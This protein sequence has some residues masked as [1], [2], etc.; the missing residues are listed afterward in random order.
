M[1]L[2]PLA[3]SLLH[4][5]DVLQRLLLSMLHAQGKGAEYSS[6]SA[7]RVSDAEDKVALEVVA[8]TSS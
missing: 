3:S 7:Q 4:H 5:H 1:S 2:P 8:E 6:S